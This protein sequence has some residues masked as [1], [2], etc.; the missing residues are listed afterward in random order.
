M[1]PAAPHEKHEIGESERSHAGHL[2][3][4]RPAAY[5]ALL[6]GAVIVSAAYG[7]WWNAIFACPASGYRSDS[8]LAYCQATGYGDYDH[9]AFW[10]DLEPDVAEAAANAEVLFVGN[11]RMQLGFSTSATDKWFASH[12]ARYFLLGFS[13]N[14]NVIFEAPLL[15][16]LSPRARVYVINLNWFFRQNAGQ[17][18]RTVLADSA[19]RAR[20]ERKRDWQPVHRSACRWAPFLC[21][22]EYV[23]Y[24]SRTTG[25]W[26]V[27]G[28]EIHGM[29]VSY[30]GDSE[31]QVTLDAYA[32]AAREFVASL[33]VD[34]K[35][36]MLTYVPFVRT[37]TAT[38]IAV[39]AALGM[40]LIAPRLD[41]LN[42]FDESHLDPPSAERWSAAFYEAAGPR[43]QA[44]LGAG[45]PALREGRRGSDDVATR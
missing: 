27:S 13:H 24:R 44:C 29:P 1:I 22:N 40:D 36:I 31:N 19:A 20:Y 39:A 16:K 2:A 9:G 15:R 3:T 18:V 21:R 45:R 37:D 8:Y 43:I 25:A 33:P 30:D 5:T 4:P 38:A 42:T 10:F 6:F 12:A 7:V 32:A 28:G 14:V 11:S 41:G 26:H 35:C 17:L 23:I 34:P